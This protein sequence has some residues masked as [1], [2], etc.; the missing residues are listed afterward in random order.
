MVYEI[1]LR[2]IHFYKVKMKDSILCTCSI[3]ACTWNA[4]YV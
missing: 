2:I 1:H 3:Q 4:S